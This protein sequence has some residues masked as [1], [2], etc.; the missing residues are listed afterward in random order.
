VNDFRVLICCAILSAS[1]WAHSEDLRPE[2]AHDFA[3]KVIAVLDGDTV[4]ILRKGGG[5]TAGPGQDHAKGESQAAHPLQA[6]PAGPP[7][8]GTHAGGLVKIRLAEIDAPEKAQAFGLASRNALAEM[9][10][11][12]QVWVSTLAVDKYGRDIAQLKV[13]G[14]SVNEEMVRRGMAWE[15]SHYHSDR[16][17]I[18]LQQEAQRAGRGLWA[19]NDPL[20]PWEWRLR[21][22]TGEASRLREQPPTASSTIK[23]SQ[24]DELGRRKQHAMET[25]ASQ[26]LSP[27]DYSCGTKQR[28]SQM[29]TCDEAYYYLTVC[30]VKALNPGG[31][32]VPCE[33]LC[34]DSGGR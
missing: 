25:D 19:Q 10:L 2:S 18:A 29:R 31:D 5:I 27:R 13:S 7:S 8:R 28:C 32:G 30:G 23:E 33:K 34:A 11:H 3:A 9:V 22:V 24:T 12:K 17:Y 20:P 6:N 15:Y 4:L 1:G 21:H 26:A 14:L 16:R